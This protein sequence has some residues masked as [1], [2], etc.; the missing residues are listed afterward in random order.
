MATN[1]YHF[2]THWRVAAKIEEVAGVLSD[3]AAL[4]RW[5]PSVYLDVR[6]LKPGDERHI[7]EEV[8]LYTKGW[9][10]Y[11]LRWRLRIVDSR[12]PHGFTLDAHGDFRGRGVWTLAQDGP[13][14]DVTYN[15]KV[16]AEK[17]L[18][19]ALSPLLKPL[20]AANHRWAMDRGEESLCL[21]LARRRARTPDELAR[22]APPP[23]PI[24]SPPPLLVGGFGLV[25]VVAAMVLRGRLVR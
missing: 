11:T 2:I 12:Y 19:R 7:G 4:A 8:G 3:A 23:G 5:W 6:V 13:W 24:P 9:L 20:F 18:L 14:V 21:E 25:A 15:W 16:R 17:P 10:P 1:D 22:V